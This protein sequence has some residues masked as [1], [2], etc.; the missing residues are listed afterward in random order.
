MTRTTAAVL[1]ALLALL[2]VPLRGAEPDDAVHI[3]PLVR[4]GRL[5]V[6]FELPGGVTDEVRETIRSGLQTS[7]VYDFELRRGVPLWLDRVLAVATVNATVQYDNLTGRHQLSR[8][9]DGRVEDARTTE[10]EAEVE[11]WLTRFERLPLFGTDGLEPNSEYYVRVRARA[12][13]RSTW[14]LLPWD[15]GG[16]WGHARFTF[17]P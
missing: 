5:L 9:I 16:V 15:R 17:L 2:A 10:S 14:S 11:R 4:D 13:P 12:R 1:A 7:F 3:T 8:S 6:S